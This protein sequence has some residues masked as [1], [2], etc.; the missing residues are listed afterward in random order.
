MR[1]LVISDVHANYA[2]LDTVLEAAMPFSRVWCL[3]DVV[4]YGPDPDECIDRLRT[5][6]IVCI[7]GNHDLAAVGSLSIDDF[8]SAAKAAVLWTR[9]H[10]GESNRSWLRS[11]SA[12]NIVTEF[13]ATLVHGSPVDPVWEYIDDVRAAHGGFEALGTRLCFNGH[14][15]VP[16]MFRA[17][18]RGSVHFAERPEIGKSISIALG[19]IMINPGSVGQ[20]RDGDPR[21]AFAIF[22]T[23]AMTIA[24]FRA[25]YDI[26][27]TQDRMKRANLPDSLSNRLQSGN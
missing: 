2:A 3:G 19:D 16:V 12:I 11:L 23:D 17:S 9:G 1:I 5:F 10:I 4:G 20:P 27:S 24:F 21:A 8:N 26:A 6:D 22:D 25:F 13:D 14:T 7:A 15:H 18:D